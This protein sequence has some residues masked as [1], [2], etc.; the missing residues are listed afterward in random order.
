MLLVRPLSGFIIC[1]SIFI[2]SQITGNI[3]ITT[4][5]VFLLYVFLEWTDMFPFY[6]KRAKVEIGGMGII[7]QN[8]WFQFS[9][10]C[11]FLVS[12]FV[13]ICGDSTCHVI[14]VGRL[15]CLL[16]ISFKPF[17]MRGWS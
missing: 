10:Q 9:L 14:C 4:E 6:N 7:S 13:I 2:F 12:K 3:C 1:F 15:K 17:S 5:H 8:Q 11:H 16:W